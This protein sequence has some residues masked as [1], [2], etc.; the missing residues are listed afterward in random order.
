MIPLKLSNET[1]LHLPELFTNTNINL[2]ARTALIN[3]HKQHF[4]ANHA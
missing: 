4:T 3:L 2:Y 1:N